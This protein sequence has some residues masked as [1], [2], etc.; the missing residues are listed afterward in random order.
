[1]KITLAQLNYTIGDFDGN[2]GKIINAVHEA[3]RQS[4]S[5]VVFSELAVCGYPPLDLLEYKSFIE[6]AEKS[7]KIIAKECLGIAAIFGAPVVNTAPLGKNL[8]NAAI[9]CVDGKIQQIIYKSLLP[10]YDVFDEYRYFEPSD[11]FELVEYKGYKIALTVCEDLW[12]K[13]PLLSGFGKNKLYKVDPIERLAAQNPDFIINIAA[14]PFAFN[15][16]D[17]K[18]EI[19]FQNASKYKM[20]VFYVN[21]V[22]AQTEIIFDG[23]SRVVNSGGFL[24]NRMPFF[25]ESVETF[26]LEEVLVSKAEE[27][28]LPAADRITKIHD[29]IVLGIRDYCSKMNFKK[30]VLGLSGGIDSAVTLVLAERALGHENVRVLLMPSQYSSDHSLK[31]A[32]D[33]AEN[34]GIQYDIVPIKDSFNQISSDLAAIFKDLPPGLTEENIQARIRGVILMAI[35]NKFGNILLNTSNK[36]EAAVGYGTLYGDMAGGISVLGD[37][38]KTDVFRLARFINKDKEIIPE[39]SIIKPPSAELRP[40]QKDSDSL[41]DY[42]LLDKILYSYIELKL[43]E[44]EIIDQGLP[45]EIV[46]KTIKMVNANEYK[47]FQTPPI[48]RVSSKAFGFGRRMPLVA[49][50]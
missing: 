28:A 2:T 40:N 12:F 20:P 37:V 8:R 47:R 5:L 45:A 4:S 24:L 29:A 43:S 26:N 18:R 27:N 42:D 1:M 10:T 7:V 25:E 48:L 30:A 14:S 6:K 31:D 23:G 35:S 3:K 19:L 33:L 34:L 38:Y 13:Q 49:K 15:H 22:G 39:N 41:P 21:Q 36:S 16:D 50:Y 32:K 9:F 17:I 44:Q 46:A 11:S